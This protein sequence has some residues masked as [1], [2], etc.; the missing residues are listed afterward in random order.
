MDRGRPTAFDEVAVVSCDIVGHS[1]ADGD[2]QLR[3]VKAIND[4]VA[5]ALQ[6]RVAERIVWSSGGDG[7]HVIFFGEGWQAAAVVLIKKLCTWAQGEQARLRVTGHVGTVTTLVG[8][9]GRTQVVGTGINFAGWLIRQATGDGVVVS[10][11]FRRGVTSVSVSADVVF[12]DERLR[13]DRN[14]IPQLLC[15]MSASNVKSTWPEAEQDDYASLKKCLH[16]KEGW[17]ALYYAKRISQINAS[18]DAVP[19]ALKSASRILKSDSVENGSFLEL[20]R[21]DELTEVLKLGHLVERKAGEM[22][23]RVD[24]PGESM[25][26][27]LRGKVGV[28][29]LEGKGLDGT[30]EPKHVHRAGEIVGELATVLKRKRTA[31]LIAVT[32]V[33][34]LSL[35]GDEVKDRLSATDA[36]KDAA[37]HYDLFVLDR[38]LQHTIQVAP[39]LLGQNHLGPLSIAPSHGSSRISE[40]EAWE[41]TVRTLLPHTELIL[42]DNGGFTLDINQVIQKVTSDDPRHGL[43]VLVSGSVQS[44]PPDNANL[45]GAQCPLLWVDVPHLLEMQPSAYTR[46]AEPI[47]VLWIGAEGIKKLTL[48]QRTELRRELENA[49]GEVPSDYQY[50]VYMCHSSADKPI[51]LEV[52]DRLW[53]EYGV[54]CWYD[55]AELRPGDLTRRAIE[56]GL[57][58]SRFFLLC[59]S[60]S[61]NAS[62]W[63]NR[64]IDSITHLDVKRVGHPKVLVLKL[65]EHES[66]D[67]AIPTIF[68]GT[69]RQHFQRSG[70]F[71]KLAEYIVSTK[72]AVTGR[73]R[74]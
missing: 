50:D 48:D 17:G 55:D 39:Y 70:D 16:E 14:S 73:A 26:V 20:L 24:D 64:E 31:D 63:A 42:V 13:V 72:R 35:I 23:C 27:I 18:D 51:V 43:F 71:E 32:D 59:A 66:N 4:I 6:S 11:A 34:L 45:S 40:R 3:R 9:D 54:R 62:A 58:T 22:I 68:R 1:S 47:M 8:A 15:L 38:V 69:K 5:N 44:M 33:A 12:H 37:K 65:Y 57:K 41:A 36:G 21:A 46:T 56:K 74:T 2:D 29:N 61:L 28:Y 52:K 53:K 10:D 7:G 25:F 60:A 67:E 30:A 19:D 49:V